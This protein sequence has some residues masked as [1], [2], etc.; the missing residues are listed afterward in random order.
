[1]YKAIDYVAYYRLLLYNI[2]SV[3]NTACGFNV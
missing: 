3:T 1:M 2:R